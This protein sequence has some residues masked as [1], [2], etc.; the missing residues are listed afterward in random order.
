[1]SWFNED[2]KDYSVPYK[3]ELTDWYTKS[4][5]YKEGM[6]T[7]EILDSLGSDEVVGDKLEYILA[8]DD[9][10][11]IEDVNE[12]LTGEFIKTNSSKGLVSRAKNENKTFFGVTEEEFRQELQVDEDTANW[13]SAEDLPIVITDEEMDELIGWLFTPELNEVWYLDWP[14]RKVK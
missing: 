2:T 9:P 13:Y 5:K 7:D 10:V 14:T 8:D 12:I 3:V 11:I 4:E 6:S 1:M